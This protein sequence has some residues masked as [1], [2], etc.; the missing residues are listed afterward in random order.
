MSQSLIMFYR[1]MNPPDILSIAHE[2]KQIMLPEIKQTVRDE[3]PDIETI[4]H[5][6]V[7]SAV[8]DVA[9]V[10]DKKLNN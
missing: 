7:Q 2:L 4:V 5:N 9:D 6:A 8:K 1:P 3:N 10:M